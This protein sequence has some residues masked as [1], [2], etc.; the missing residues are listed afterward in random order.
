MKKRRFL[1][2]QIVALI[3]VL[4]AGA[5]MV[6]WLMNSIFLEKYYVFQKKATMVTDFQT[7]SDASA[8]N[9]LDDGG[10]DTTFDNMCANGNMT[11]L[12]IN[13]SGVVVRSSASDM[14]TLRQEMLNTMFDVSNAET[15]LSGD[16]YQ[17]LSSKETRLNS[18]YLI[19]VGQLTGGETILM[20][21][22]L[23]SIHESAM[24]SNRLLLLV[25]LIMIVVS[26]LVGW[27]L[28]RRITKPILQL[29]DISKKMVGLDFEAKYVPG[30]W[31]KDSQLKRLS[32][33]SDRL[34]EEDGREQISGNEI[35]LLGDHM[36]RLSETL[37]RTISELKSANLEL[38]RDIQKKEEIDEMRK[39]FLSN[40]SHELKTPLALIQG[41]AEGLEECIN[42]DPESRDFYCDVIMDEAGK[43]NRMVQKLLTLNQLEFGN[44]QVVM[45]RFDIT[46]LIMGVLNSARILMEKNGITLEAGNLPQTFVWGDEFKMEEVV[47]NYLSNAINHCEGEKKI[48]VS[49]TMREGLLRVSVFNTGKP[50]PEEDIGQIWDK[51]YKV[52]KART[53]EYGGSGIGLSIVKAIMDGHGQSCGVEN[54]ED[55]V[56]FWFELGTK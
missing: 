8:A 25:G 4:S 43:M 44:D 46:E 54:K 55:G 48:C 14:S 1:T 35:D 24:L 13:S 38:T 28:A 7:M 6:C 12:V 15:V 36:N 39:E 31:K 19:L 21:T 51:F 53:R 10:F 11:I 18:E 17:I 47:T 26:C 34:A 20:R 32:V 16:N 40:V 49:Y 30:A 27:V 22:A 2:I 23:E 37:E 5:I 9:I 3:C 56:E 29:T 52:D 33:I 41:Y 50:I 42:D 45:E